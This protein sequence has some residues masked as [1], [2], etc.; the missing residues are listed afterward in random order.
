[1]KKFIIRAGIVV[2]AL[3]VI[4][5]V[6]VFLSLNS[7]VKK[8]VETVGPVITKV[9]VKLG[10]ADI[11]PFSGGGRLMKL[12]IG[13]PTGFKSPSAIEVGDV[14]VSAAIG[15]LLTDTIVVNEVNIQNAEITFEGSLQG[16]NLTKLMDNINGSN[17]SEPKPK[18]S[19]A[20][21]AGTA[22]KF[23]VKDLVVEGTK[24]HLSL[25]V[26][27]VGN[28]DTTVPLPPLHLQNI[29]TPENPVTASQL[30][31]AIMKPLLAS[32]TQAATDEVGKMGG[33]VKDIG[34]GAVDQLGKAAGGITDMFKKK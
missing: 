4:G 3:V 1:M 17:A 10:A 26:P 5:V 15:S 21:A 24:V 13:N 12:F 11:S 7:I 14:K 19:A 31:T 30:A 16:N 27:V 25:T 8:G 18:E 9:D 20:P 2:V 33:K 28:L 32:V 34:K 6:V 29:G 23:A 22:K